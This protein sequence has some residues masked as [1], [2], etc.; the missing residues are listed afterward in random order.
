MSGTK[1]AAFKLGLVDALTAAMPSG[2]L[3]TYGH[4]G[5][6]SADD[7][8]AVRSV[9]SDLAVATMSTNRSR[10]E[11]L[12]ARVTFSCWRGGT[13][14]QTVTERAYALLELLDTSLRVTDITVGG[15]VRDSM[16]SGHELAEGEEPDDLTRGRIAEIDVTITAR[17]R[18]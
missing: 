10:E 15:T 3:V 16:I 13:D 14:Q 1:A 4:P 18:I 17:A 6:L 7:I 12:T 9:S 5:A 8:V 2:V 11:T